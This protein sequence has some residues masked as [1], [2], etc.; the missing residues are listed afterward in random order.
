MEKLGIK[1]LLR[2]RKFRCAPKTLP[3]R[4][5][6]I[7]LNIIGHLL[8]EYWENFLTFQ[9]DQY[10]TFEDDDGKRSNVELTLSV[11]TIKEFQA[12]YWIPWQ[13]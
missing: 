8:C 1:I 10:E 4:T 7:V 5:Q 9:R 6:G 13:I 11:R 3:A 12:K 2:V